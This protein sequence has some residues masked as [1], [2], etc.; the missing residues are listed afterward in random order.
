MNNITYLEI[1]KENISTFINNKG[2]NTIKTI[3]NIEDLIKKET[4]LNLNMKQCIIYN[5][6]SVEF[7]NIADL[8]IHL[9]NILEARF[10]N[11]DSEIAVRVDEDNNNFIGSIIFDNDNAN[12]FIKDDLL[13][14]S[15]DAETLYTK[16]QVKKYINYDEDAQAYIEYVKPVKLI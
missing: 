5:Y 16:L 13:I 11:E 9:E 8:D 1:N 10:F 3:E 2:I 14:Y 4:L 6:D 7:G 15:K 12:S